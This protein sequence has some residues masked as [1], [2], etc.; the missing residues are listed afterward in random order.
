M[1]RN[2]MDLVVRKTKT[3][4]TETSCHFWIKELMNDSYEKLIERK[5]F[6]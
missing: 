2:R 3:A 5:Q 6:L 4:T 1:F